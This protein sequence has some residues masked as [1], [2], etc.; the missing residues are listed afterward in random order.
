MAFK[1]KGHR[2]A[3]KVGGSSTWDESKYK[4]EPSG[5]ERVCE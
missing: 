4:R 1:L 2:L 5:S 3:G